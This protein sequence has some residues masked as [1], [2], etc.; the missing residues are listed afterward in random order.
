[1]SILLDTHILIW[2]LTEPEKLGETVRA[3]IE[4]GDGVHFS[5]VSIL[6]IAIKSQTLRGD[7]PLSADGILD[8][9]VSVGLSEVAV[10][11][12]A[13][14]YVGQLPLFHRDP[15]DRLLVAQAIVGRLQ[16]YT[17]DRRLP[18]YSELVVRV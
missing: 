5:P 13:A 12:R 8:E 17:V 16:L 3:R 2:A 14:A 7:F 15:F 9:A 11:S 10:D 4:R 18:A 1:M 6:E